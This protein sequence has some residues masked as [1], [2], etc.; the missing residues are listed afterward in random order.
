MLQKGEEKYTKYIANK[1]VSL[2]RQKI[3]MDNFIFT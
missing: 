2:S 1:F 3:V